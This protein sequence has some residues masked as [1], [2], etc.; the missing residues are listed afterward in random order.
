ML[1]FILNVLLFAQKKL[2]QKL[3]L[4]NTIL[5]YNQ[6]LS[7]VHADTMAIYVIR[8]LSYFKIVLLF[9]KMLN[10]N[11]FNKLQNLFIYFL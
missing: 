10:N 4:T 7:Y 6:I 1:L 2:Y 5:M 8:V 11:N 3:I 9:L